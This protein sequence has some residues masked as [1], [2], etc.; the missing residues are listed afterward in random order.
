[1]TWG[2][3]RKSTLHLINQVQGQNRIHNRK[4]MISPKQGGEGERQIK[5]EDE[6][7]EGGKDGKVSERGRKSLYQEGRE[8]K[9]STS[10]GTWDESKQTGA[11][12]RP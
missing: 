12:M 5:K 1:M 7:K 10:Q 9:Y 6:E 3:E 8:N 11:V 4:G 2:K